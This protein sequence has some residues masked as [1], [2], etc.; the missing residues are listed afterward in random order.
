MSVRIVQWVFIV[1]ISK[2]MIICMLDTASKDPGQPLEPLEPLAESSYTAHSELLLKTQAFEPLTVSFGFHSSTK[3]PIKKWSGKHHRNPCPKHHPHNHGAIAVISAHHPAQWG[4]VSRPVNQPKTI[5]PPW[6]PTTQHQHIIKK[7]KNNPTI[8]CWMRWK[9]GHHP[10]YQ[11]R[12]SLLALSP[13]LFFCHT[14]KSIV[15]QRSNPTPRPV[16]TPIDR[17]PIHPFPLSHKTHPRGTRPP[18]SNPRRRRNKSNPVLVGRPL[19]N[20]CSV[21]NKCTAMSSNKVPVTGQATATTTTTK[22]SPLLVHYCFDGCPWRPC[23]KKSNT[24]VPSHCTLT[25][26]NSMAWQCNCQKR[27]SLVWHCENIS[28]TPTPNI[29]VT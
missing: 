25:Q 1:L 27:K 20:N 6:C 28:E 23:K 8:N 7:P 21:S 12:A 19:H 13:H 18:K 17:P 26:H 11:K 24:C 10:R 9:V 29:V 4:A 16:R 15:H 22:M 14:N 2:N 5:P 3:C